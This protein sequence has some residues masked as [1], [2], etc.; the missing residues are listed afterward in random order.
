MCRATIPRHFVVFVQQRI[1]DLR[2][3]PDRGH[4]RAPVNPGP[5]HISVTGYNA[6][7]NRDPGIPDSL[8]YPSRGCSRVVG[9]TEDPGHSS[10]PAD[11]RDLDANL[12][13]T[14]ECS[15]TRENINI[16]EYFPKAGFIV[17]PAAPT[18]R[19]AFHD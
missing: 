13:S 4:T 12:E 3:Y 2:V 18:R 16:N 1:V 6:G 8:E 14:W 9:D 19:A 5:R 7:Y 15:R 10:D 11:T 17:F